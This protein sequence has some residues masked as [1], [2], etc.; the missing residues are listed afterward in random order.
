MTGNARLDWFVEALSAGISSLP[1][2]PASAVEIEVADET[3][4][5]ETKARCLSRRWEFDAAVA[6][7]YAG[8]RAGEEPPP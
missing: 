3:M 7:Y 2:R 6:A 5:P 4:G 8:A 1:S